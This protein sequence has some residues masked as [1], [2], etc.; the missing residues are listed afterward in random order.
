MVFVLYIFVL[1]FIFCNYLYIIYDHS[2]NLN[3]CGKNETVQY[4]VSLTITG[5]IWG[6]LMEKLHQELGL[7]YL[8]GQRWFRKLRIFYT[9]VKISPKTIFTNVLPGDRTWQTE[10]GSKQKT[11][12]LSL[13]PYT[14]K[15]E[16]LRILWRVQAPDWLDCLVGA[17]NYD[18]R[19]LRRL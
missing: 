17:L 1:Y 19:S 10:K 8:R 9:M 13:F 11:W 12:F 15:V 2:R 5:V 6:S 7:E 16:A 3:L 4:K 14:F 18:S